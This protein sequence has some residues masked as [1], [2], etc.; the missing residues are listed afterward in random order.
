MTETEIII[1][2]GT[3][4]KDYDQHTGTVGFDSRET[5]LTAVETI[6]NTARA[7]GANARVLY[8]VESLEM[9]ED[10]REDIAEACLNAE[11]SRIVV[12]HGTDTMVESARVTKKWLENTERT[13]VFTGAMRPHALGD[14]D[15]GFNL[16]FAMATAQ[17]QPSGVY[18]AMD[19]QVFDPDNARKN[20][21]TLQFEGL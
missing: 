21:D 12:V 5:G 7:I 18:V 2:G 1:T 14:S 3:F 20:R 17:Q 11:V 6:L 8:L 9:T 13:V 19:G 16:G 4:E 10:Q 15:A